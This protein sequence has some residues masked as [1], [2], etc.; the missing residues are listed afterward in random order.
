MKLSY[1][2]NFF[3]EKSDLNRFKPL[4]EEEVKE[5]QLKH[6]KRGSSIE[7][8][9]DEDCDF[10]FSNM[11]LINLCQLYIN[12]NLSKFEVSYISDALL[13][14]SK[15]IFQSELVEDVLETFCILGKNNVMSIDEI[16]NLMNE[17]E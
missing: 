5:Y 10:Y 7:I 6:K 12:E 4:L 8:K 2:A 9:L 1:I 3:N 11:H 14:S 15:V 17:L 13:L 16:I